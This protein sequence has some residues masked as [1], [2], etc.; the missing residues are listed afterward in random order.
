MT[1][2]PFAVAGIIEGFYGKP[3]THAQRL[4]MME[5][6]GRHDMNTF[7]YSPKDDRLLRRDWR[8]PYAG[9]ELS[10]LSEL[11]AQCRKTSLDFVFCL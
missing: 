4:D 7:V 9:D 2:S 3:W 6:I 8:E 1:T 10:R 5:F 11:M